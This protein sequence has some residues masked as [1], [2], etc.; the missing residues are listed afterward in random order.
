MDYES[1]TQTVSLGYIG[2]R[3]AHYLQ[4][5][6]WTNAGGGGRGLWLGVLGSGTLYPQFPSFDSAKLGTKG[7]HLSETACQAHPWRC[8]RIYSSVLTAALFGWYSYC[9][10]FTDGGTEAEVLLNFLQQRGRAK[11]I[12]LALSSKA[13]SSRGGRRGLAGRNRTS[14][15]IYTDAA[16]SGRASCSFVGATSSAARQEGQGGGGLSRSCAAPSPPQCLNQKNT[17]P[18][19]FPHLLRAQAVPRGLPAD[20]NRAPGPGW[21]GGMMMPSPPTQVPKR[22]EKGGSEPTGCCA[23]SLRGVRCKR[24]GPEPAP[25]SRSSSALTGWAH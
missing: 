15:A 4:K 24:T 13:S 17:T 8:T 21:G 1:R 11:P 5:L 7:T 2:Q 16:V 22:Q 10:H 20:A 18:P 19:H 12:P 6:P 3:R 25:G 9:P 23:G 14:S